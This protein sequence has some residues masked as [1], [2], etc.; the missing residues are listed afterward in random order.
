MC[1]WKEVDLVPLACEDEPQY[2]YNMY[3]TDTNTAINGPWSACQR[4][5]I[6]MAF[7]WWADGPTLNAGLIALWFFQGIWDPD[8]YNAKKSYIFVIFQGGSRPPVPPSGSGHVLFEQPQVPQHSIA[9]KVIKCL[10][11]DKSNLLLVK[12]FSTN[13]L[14]FKIQIPRCVKF[15]QGFN[16]EITGIKL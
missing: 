15:N 3:S 5:A 10:D 4:N 6:E 7:C 11:C 14:I 12:E 2:T 16:F 9:C 1:V 13:I 8:Q